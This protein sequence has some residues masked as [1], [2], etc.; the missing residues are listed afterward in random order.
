MTGSWLHRQWGHFS[1]CHW[2]WGTSSA[3]S[4]DQNSASSERLLPRQISLG[5]LTVYARV[6]LSSM[7]SE[8][9]SIRL[10]RF[11]Q[12]NA[13]PSICS[14]NWGRHAHSFGQPHFCLWALLHNHL[15][16][17]RYGS[18]GGRIEATGLFASFYKSYI[19]L[20]LVM[21]ALLCLLLALNSE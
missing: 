3:L 15:L 17:Y 21:K 7:T 8:F 10:S 12:I 18:T 5:N 2:A 20:E 9:Q 19:W 13:Q 1:T 16:R 4:W 11:A 14:E 6:L